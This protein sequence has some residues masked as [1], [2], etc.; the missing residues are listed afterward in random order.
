M[1]S[2]SGMVLKTALITSLSYIVV[3]LDVTIVNVAIPTFAEVF[4]ADISALQWIPD[5]YIIVFAGLLLCAGGLSDRFG[6]RAINIWGIII[7]MFASLL[8]AFSHSIGVLLLGR[9]LQG[10]GAALILPS[11][12][13]II[14]SASAGS[15]SLRTKAIGWWSAVGGII[16]ASGPLLGGFILEF[17]SWKLLFLIN[18]PVCLTG[19]LLTY[20]YIRPP[21]LELGVKID[22]K[23]ICLFISLSF[24]LVFLL[25]NPSGN[26]YVSMYNLIILILLIFFAFFLIRHIG[27]NNNAFITL[28]MLRAPVFSVSLYIGAIMNFSFYG[29]IFLITVYFQTYRGF[30]P[31]MTGLALLTFTVIALANTLSVYISKSIGPRMTITV[32]LLFSAATYF[33]LSLMIYYETSYISFVYVL[34]LMPIGGGIALPTLLSS[35]IHFTPSSKTATASAAINAMRQ[36]GSAIGVAVLGFLVSGLPTTINTGASAGF[37]ISGLVMLTGASV[38]YIKFHETNKE[39]IINEN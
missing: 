22:I 12:L 1:K 6:S 38:A 7:F 16:S 35:F 39:R 36:F 32:G 17:Y 15:R 13:A 33:S 23:G 27:M 14:S 4:N 5:A 26:S 18:I 31:I 21:P 19:I 2:E 29:S 30:S 28:D 10:I 24:T 37:F 3:L 8:C 20:K 25:I 34:F 9:V 11:S